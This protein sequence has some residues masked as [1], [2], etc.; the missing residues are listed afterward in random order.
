MPAAGAEPTQAAIPEH[1]QAKTVNKHI[2]DLIEI[3][4]EVHDKAYGAMSDQTLWMT[5][6]TK[7]QSS[8]IKSKNPMAWIRLFSEFFDVHS[9]RIAE[10]V[11]IEEEED[12]KVNDSWLRCETNFETRS[13]TAGAG[14]GWTPRQATCK[15]YVLYYDPAPKY[16]AVSI[17][18]SEIYL[19]AC[20]L[21][22]EKGSTNTRM[23]SY[24][25]H[26]LYNLYALFSTAVSPLDE[27]HKQL[28]KNTKVLKA[29]LDEISPVADSGVGDGMKGFSKIMASVMKSA[30]ID[31]GANSEQLESAMQSTMQGD[32]VQ[33]MGKVVSKIMQS[34]GAGETKDES[35]DAVLDR[36]GDVFKDRELRDML[37]TSAKE[38]ADKVA[39][40][41]ASIPTAESVGQATPAPSV[42]LPVPEE[43]HDDAAEQE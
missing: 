25:V 35:T 22:K 11:F 2:T 18:I 28:V 1:P 32:A 3:S 12:T 23:F 13:A 9:E 15:G 31:I 6:L 30:G 16:R 37:S 27:S 41:S 8:Y 24:P 29:F 5:R 21:S 39:T 43:V 34:V 26:I 17:A 38:T 10:D 19:C 36:L 7:F 40:L 14:T 20:K 33:T 42:P 4:K